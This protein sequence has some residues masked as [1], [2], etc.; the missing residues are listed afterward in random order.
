MRELIWQLLVFT[1]GL[2]WGAVGAI[3]LGVASLFLILPWNN[4][5]IA[6]TF[7]ALCLPVG[8]ALGIWLAAVK[9]RQ[10]RF[11]RACMAG[12]ALATLFCVPGMYYMDGRLGKAAGN[13]PLSGLVEFAGILLFFVLA[14]DSVLL[15]L[16]GVIGA[17]ALALQPPAVDVIQ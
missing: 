10:R 16:S 11:H 17:V 12:G 7:S 3:S 5:P 2:L 9:F 14:F 13:G 15:T 4:H 8:F 6:E 1:Y